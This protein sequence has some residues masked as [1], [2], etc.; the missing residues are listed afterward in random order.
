MALSKA[1]VQILG[2]S[3]RHEK[4]VLPPARRPTRLVTGDVLWFVGWDQLGSS[5]HADDGPGNDTSLNNHTTLTS[6]PITALTNAT[7]SAGDPSLTSC[8]SARSSWSA[9]NSS[10]FQ[11]PGHVHTYN[12]STSIS[13]SA[14]REQSLTDLSN[15]TAGYPTAFATCN[16]IPYATDWWTP[17][18]ITEVPATS[19]A[20]FPT[21]APS[22]SV[23]DDQCMAWYLTNNVCA[24]ITSYPNTGIKTAPS[25][26]AL[27]QTYAPCPSPTQFSAPWTSLPNEPQCQIEAGMVKLHYWPRTVAGGSGCN[28]T[29]TSGPTNTTRVAVIGTATITSPDVAISIPWIYARNVESQRWGRY[30]Q[31]VVVTLPPN[32]IRS[33]QAFIGAPVYGTRTGTSFNFD[34][35]LPGYP[36]WGEWLG[37][38]D[39]GNAWGPE[40][41]GEGASEQK[42]NKFCG[43]V[44]VDAYEPQLVVPSQLS[45]LVP[46]WGSQ[47]CAGIFALWDPPTALAEAATVA[48]LTTAVTV[49]A[50]TTTSAVPAV[51]PTRA[52]PQTTSVRPTESSTQGSEV[53]ASNSQRSSSANSVAAAESSASAPTSTS[54]VSGVASV[55]AV[56]QAT[57]TAQT[58]SQAPAGSAGTSPESD[59]SSS[60]DGEGNTA[61]SERVEVSSSTPGRTATTNAVETPSG[62]PTT[63]SAGAGVASYIASALGVTRASTTTAASIDG[64]GQATMPTSAS[65][66]PGNAEPGSPSPAS[67]SSAVTVSS[68]SGAAVELT[69]STRSGGDQTATLASAFSTPGNAGAGSASPPTPSSSVTAGSESEAAVS[70]TVSTRSGDSAGD[71]GVQTT[72]V[73]QTLAAIS[74]LAGVIIQN[75]ATTATHSTVAGVILQSTASTATHSSNAADPT[76]ATGVGANPVVSSADPSTLV[77]IGGQVYTVTT[78]SAGSTVL[79]NGQATLTVEAGSGVATPSGEVVS[80]SATD[81]LV[82]ANHATASSVATG[83]DS[84]SIISSAPQSIA[85]TLQPS[86]VSVFANAYTTVTITGSQVVT[87]GQTIGAGSSGSM[88]TEEDTGAIPTAALHSFGQTDATTASVPSHRTL[89]LES[90]TIT[91]S[92]GGPAVSAESRTYSEATDGA[93]VAV[94]GSQTTTIAAP[95]SIIIVGSEIFTATHEA[96]GAEVLENASTSITVSAGGPAILL[97][98][99]T[100]SA[101]PSGHAVVVSG[102]QASTVIPPTVAATGA[103]ASTVDAA[104]SPLRKTASA[105]SSSTTATSASSTRAS[106]AGQKPTA[107]LLLVVGMA[108]ALLV[109]AWMTAV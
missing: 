5:I 100:V 68:G 11:L 105:V 102:S 3:R 80:L 66:T 73:G 83:T 97:G 60:S 29:L 26:C 104:S 96:S 95:S 2:L 67:S 20:P 54:V 106:S 85:R 44:W 76:V 4:D 1:H 17:T 25:W 45:T 19:T 77:S 57:S 74:T 93:I 34:D 91:L 109:S 75:A 108:L 36:S 59:T 46:E 49:E 94:F 58:D 9:A 16:G 48:G 52:A 55:Q 70:I 21:P 15:V 31:D 69:V 40:T 14:Q 72:I 43:T 107:A 98:S 38:Y 50:A 35:L 99:E 6:R 53:A 84:G 87:E 88:A 65:G 47:N 33:L 12:V 56:P 81:G 79:V 24:G 63:S 37:Q 41:T 64:V 7:T 62:T 71:P 23:D 78:Q 86:G 32:D 89:H 13:T 30:L 10:W 90:A 42:S 28:Q 22:C 82:S 61:G 101:G 92:P 18:I 27:Y 8:I 51:T 103:Q 39:C